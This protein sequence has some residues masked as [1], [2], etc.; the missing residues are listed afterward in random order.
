LIQLFGIGLTD[1]PGQSS[2][3]SHMALDAAGVLECTL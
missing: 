1:L 3:V 2:C